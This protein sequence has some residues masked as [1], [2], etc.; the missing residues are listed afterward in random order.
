MKLMEFNVK[1]TQNDYSV[2]AKSFLEEKNPFFQKYIFIVVV[3]ISVFLGIQDKIYNILVTPNFKFPETLIDSNK[4]LA[5]IYYLLLFSG[6]LF[7]FRY[8][9]LRANKKRVE[10]ITLLSAEKKFELTENEI[11][12]VRGGIETKLKYGLIYNCK[13]TDKYCYLYIDP[14]APYIIPNTVENYNEFLKILSEK[15]NFNI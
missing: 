14:R 10:I 4:I 5:I 8:L 13:V 9:V 15:T 2:Y 12:I 7:L 6:L 1:N 3:L 11:I